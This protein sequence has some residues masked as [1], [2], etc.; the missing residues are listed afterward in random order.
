MKKLLVTGLALVV[1]CFAGLG[2]LPSQSAPGELQK[3]REELAGLLTKYTEGHPAVQ[4][5][6]QQVSALE[7]AESDRLQAELG[8]LLE[9]DINLH[10]LVQQKLQEIAAQK[11]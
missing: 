6:R 3:A 11:S 9:R 10:R 5:K 8:A 2:T 7:A 4:V 1:S